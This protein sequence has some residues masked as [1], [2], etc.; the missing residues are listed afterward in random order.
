[1]IKAATVK[2]KHQS[3]P[4]VVKTGKPGKF[5][6]KFNLLKNWFKDYIHGRLSIKEQTF[7]AKRLAFLMKA[8]VSML[9]SIHILREQTRSKRYIAILDVV[10]NDIKG[11]QQLSKSLNKFPRAFGAFTIGII[12]VGESSGTLSHNLNYLA[13]ELKKTQAL[14]RKVVGAL[15]YPAI[16]TVA[17]VAITALLTVFIFPKIM[18][19]FTSL[20]IT[21]PLTTRIMIFVSTFLLNH[22]LLL[23]AILILILITIYIC[24]KASAICHYYF[25]KIFLRIPIVGTLIRLYNLGAFTRTLGLLLKSGFT[26]SEALVVTAETTANKVY[27]SAIKSLTEVVLRGDRISGQ[28]AKLP[29]LFPDIISQMIAVGEKSGSLSD[30]FVYISEHYDEEVNEYTKNLSGLI[31]PVLMICMGLAVGFLAISV[32]TP[33]YSITQHFPGSR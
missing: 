32:I 6:L 11:G 27:Q 15:I 25:D 22:G 14:K 26:L 33:I 5:D 29:R 4:L 17:T 7:F 31:E 3:R 23:L 28:I 19:V 16:I 9:D 20:H 18:P 2:P 30:T 13:D 24:V 1:M 12:K 8:G 21:L 10:I